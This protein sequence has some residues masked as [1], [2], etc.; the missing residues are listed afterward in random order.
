MIIYPWKTFHLHLGREHPTV[1]SSLITKNDSL[2]FKNQTTSCP[3]ITS[4]RNKNVKHKRGR[5]NSTIAGE[6][7]EKRTTAPI[8]VSDVCLNAKAHWMAM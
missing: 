6:Y 7:E 3:P 2:A 5:P 8:P 4:S 1:P